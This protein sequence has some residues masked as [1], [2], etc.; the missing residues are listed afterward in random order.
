MHSLQVTAQACDNADLLGPPVMWV[1]VFF[2][3][4]SSGDQTVVDPCLLHSRHTAVV[5]RQDET[6][7]LVS[8]SILLQVPFTSQGPG[9][10]DPTNTTGVPPW[11]V[12]L[13][14]IT[15]ASS[16]LDWSKQLE[17]CQG[18]EAV[19]ELGSE[20]EWVKLNAGQ[21][22]FYRVN[23]TQPMWASLAAAAAASGTANNSVTP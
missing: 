21:Y 6:P 15:S 1:P 19:V 23:Y 16:R 17:S 3:A 8:C 13:P 9:I 2:T 18:A 7:G 20:Q 22:G 4:A 14:F 12:P 10:C 11:W 5:I